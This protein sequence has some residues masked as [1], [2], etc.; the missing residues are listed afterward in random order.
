VNVELDLPE[1]LS[2]R[3]S[4]GMFSQVVSNLLLNAINHAFEPEQQER[5][6]RIGL[7][8]ASDSCLLSVRDNGRG[9]APELRHRLFEPFFTTK[10]GA[11]GSGLG[12]HIVQSLCQ[13]MGGDIRLDDSP[14]PGLG[15]LIR[16]PRALD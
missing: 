10:R 11:G 5:E 8:S 3:L 15:F 7:K 12:L 9:V 1:R 16:L 2:L 6:L 4:G 13:R 14:G